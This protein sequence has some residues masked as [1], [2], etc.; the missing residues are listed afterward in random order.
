MFI[1]HAADEM[2]KPSMILAAQVE[3]IPLQ[4]RTYAHYT[5]LATK[6]AWFNKNARAYSNSNILQAC[7]TNR[8]LE[9]VLLWI[10]WQVLLVLLI[11]SLAFLLLL[12]N[13][14]ELF[15]LLLYD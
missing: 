12:F 11:A 6:D 10:N 1:V 13:D 14:T 2:I 7:A 15:F 3:S 8:A 5:S 4:S 9:V